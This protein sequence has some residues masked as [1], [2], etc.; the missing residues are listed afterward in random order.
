MTAASELGGKI[1]AYLSG[2]WTELLDVAPIDG[3]RG[4][5]DNKPETRIAD[6]DELSFEL[7]NNS[8]IYTPGV[9]AGFKKGTQIKLVL[10]YETESLIKFRG[11]IDDIKPESTGS[12]KTVK[13]VAL[14]WF[15]YASKYPVVNPDLLENVTGDEAITTIIDAMPVQPQAKSLDTGKTV[16]STMFDTVRGNTKAYTEFSKIAFSEVG[17]VY[18]RADP[19]TGETI[20][21][22]SF[23]YRNGTRVIAP[24]P[25]AAADA[26][27]FLK[28]DGGYLLKEDGGKIILNQTESITFDDTFTKV[29]VEYGRNIVNRFT[30]N[31]YPK[32]TD[33]IP[34]L[35][36]EIENPLYMA[37]GKVETFR[38]FWKDPT[39]KRTINAIPPT[40]NSFTK[41]LCHFDSIIAGRTFTDET[42]RAWTA[43]EDD[44]FVT[45]TVKFGTGALYLDGTSSY[46]TTPDTAD[47]DFGNS[48]FCVE[49]WEYRFAAT[50]GMTTFSRDGTDATPSF[51]FGRSNGVNLYI[52]ISSD[53]VTMDIANGKS[54]GAITLNTW[55]H[56]AVSR[57]GST[58][59]AWKNGVQTDTWTSSG[60][61][62]AVATPL[63]LGRNNATYLNACIDDV[64]ISVGDAVYTAAFTPPTIEHTI[65]G[66][67]YSMFTGQDGSGTEITSTLS[68][69]ADYGTEG[70]TFTITNGS[71]LGGYLTIKVYGYGIYSD[72]AIEKSAEDADSIDTYG[73]QN[74]SLQQQYQQATY[75]GK[76]EAER[77]V[78]LEK[79]PRTV[80]NS[81]TMWANRDNQHMMAFLYIDI[82]DLV[83]LKIDKH[84]ID[85]LFYIQ[86]ISFRM[87]GRLAEFTWIVKEAFTWGLGLSPVVCEFRDGAINYGYIP[88]VS[89]DLATKRGFSAWFYLD[90]ISATQ[91]QNIV[92]NYAGSGDGF[93]VYVKAHATKRVFAFFKGFGVASSGLWSTDT[94]V[95]AFDTATWTH[96]FVEYDS[97]SAASDPVLYI[98]GVV[99]PLI[100]LSTPVGVAPSEVGL[101]L[102]IGD[103]SNSVANFGGKIKDVRVYNMNSTTNSAAQISAGLTAEGAYGSGW[104]DGMVFQSF[105]VRTRDLTAYTDLVLT[106]EKLLDGYN[107]CVGTPVIN[108]ASAI[109]VRLP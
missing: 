84:N 93:A 38:V 95:N 68:A 88:Q 44:C 72:S 41:Y 62:F 102:S 30:A 52:D 4:M 20:K 77:V 1:Y 70:A 47:L 31:A 80:L 71:V 59:Y 48:D 73:Y 69:G 105:A 45:N 100:E 83:R 9:T 60:I 104:Y 7:N 15:D 66:T 58:F 29:D 90:S 78:E 39:G 11:T 22:E 46:A 18:A 64:Q 74:D 63:Y 13:V 36:Y 92:S 49:W 21:F 94:A 51:L 65:L 16:F 87:Q 53:G 25:I 10:T 8:G 14:G 82:G 23:D 24:I 27:F 42:G 98:N 109:T 5:G 55:N 33:T 67:T 57:S 76:L 54:L 86:G 26:G 75:T 79:Q 97:S 28:E 106:D 85:A 6:I 103:W 17:Y 101:N 91:D 37:S 61:I 12:E 2:V 99:V 3:S 35:L 56:F 96:A 108:A 40:G 107:G 43:S 32:R 50:S 34:V 19:L 81:V 89:D